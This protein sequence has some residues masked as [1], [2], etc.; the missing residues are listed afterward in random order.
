MKIF[1]IDN[2]ILTDNVI[3]QQYGC[4]VNVKQ[5]LNQRLKNKIKQTQK[6]I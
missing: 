3:N 2:N 6:H 5:Q 1:F 4:N